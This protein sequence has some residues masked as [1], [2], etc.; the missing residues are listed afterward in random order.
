MVR[1][2]WHSSYH[3]LSR[4]KVLSQPAYSEEHESPACR[5]IDCLEMPEKDRIN[6]TTG[7][8]FKI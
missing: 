5:A 8:D 3:P 7:I 6:A 2:L 1:C 4:V